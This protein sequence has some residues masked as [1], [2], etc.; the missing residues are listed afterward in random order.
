[1][2][3]ELRRAPLYHFPIRE[4]AAERLAGSRIPHL[5]SLDFMLERR[6]RTNARPGLKSRS[7]KDGTCYVARTW[8]HYELKLAMRGEKSVPRLAY[9]EAALGLMSPSRITSACAAGGEPDDCYIV[10]AD[11]SK[12]RPDLA[13][14]VV[15]TKRDY[16]EVLQRAK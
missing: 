10:G 16:R 1:M 9:L 4:L 15:W 13:I 3:A 12:D 14:E 11:Q 8:K 6:Q 7:L 5:R 2:G